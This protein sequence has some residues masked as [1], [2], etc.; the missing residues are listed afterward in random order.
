MHSKCSAVIENGLCKLLCLRMFP[1]ISSIARSI[2]VDNAIEPVSNMPDSW[3]CLKRNHKVYAFLPSGL[4]PMAKNCISEA[5]SAS[6]TDNYPEESI[7][8]TL[9]PRHTTEFRA[10]YWSS[11]GESDPSVPETLVYK[12]VSQ[13]CLVTEIHLQPFQG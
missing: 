9:E 5:I 12:L 3:E 6:S 1:E 7:L 2:E 11:K 13:L 4:T 10:S 8:N